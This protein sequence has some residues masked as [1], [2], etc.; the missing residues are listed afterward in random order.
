MRAGRPGDIPEVAPV[1]HRL[2]SP[3]G[4]A[5]ADARAAGHPGAE[6]RTRLAAGPDPVTG[7]ERLRQDAFETAWRFLAHR[8]RTEAELVARLERN[9]VAPEL[10]E[11]ILDELRSGGYVDDAGFAKRFAEDRRNLDQWGNE[12]IERRLAELGIAREHIAAALA[13]DDEH[14]ELAAAAALLARRFPSPPET[15]RELERALGFLVRRGYE[16]EL[17]H[18]A[19]RRHG[20]FTLDS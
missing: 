19:L 3:S 13:G 7:A 2:T 20:A 18:D 10:I 1:P 16:L 12:R 9:D 14:D 15:P 5:A 4:G 11:E 6:R 17:A 8:E